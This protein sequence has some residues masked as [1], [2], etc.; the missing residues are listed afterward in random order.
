MNPQLS[1]SMDPEKF[2]TIKNPK[3]HPSILL[4]TKE[5]FTEILRIGDFKKLWFFE[6][7]IFRKK[8][9]FSC[10]LAMRNMYYVL[11]Q[12]TKLP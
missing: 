6:S 7:A 2:L 1:H 3:L 10:F 5:I 12:C 11:L 8:T 4:T 9:F